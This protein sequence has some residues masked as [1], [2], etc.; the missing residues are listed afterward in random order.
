ME[1]V[2]GLVGGQNGTDL[3]GTF[4]K[5]AREVAVLGEEVRASGN[6]GFVPTRLKT[7][8]VTLFRNFPPAEQATVLELVRGLMHADGLITQPEKLLYEEL[9]G[10]FTGPPT[11]RAAATTAT[12]MVAPAS[13]TGKPVIVQPAM[14]VDLQALGH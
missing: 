8:A 6:D 14:R 12:D 11:P 9:I 13:T 7:R 1:S 3:E 4:N 5:L 2:R 10:Y